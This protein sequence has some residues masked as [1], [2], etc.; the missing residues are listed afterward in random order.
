RQQHTQRLYLGHD[1][2]ILSL[3]IHPVKDYVATGQVGRDAAIHV[4]DTQTLKCLSLLKG[5]H[6]RGVCAL[7]FSADGKCLASVGLDDNHAIVFWD[8]KKGEKLAT[9][10]GHK[11]KIFVV[12]CNPHHVDKLVTVG[13]KHIKFWQ[14]TG[15]GFTSKRGTFGTTGKLETMMSVSYGRIEDIVFS[16]AATGDIYIWKDTLLLKTVKAHDGPVFAMHALDKSLF[17]FAIIL[18]LIFLYSS[19]LLLEDNPS[20]RAISLGH[21]H[22]LVGT[23]NGEILEIDKSGPMTLLVQ[24]HME[25]EVWGLA[26]HPLLP[27]CA[28]VSDDKTLRIWELSSQHR[29]LAVRKLKKGGRCCAFSPDGKALAVGLNDGSFLVV[30]ADTVEDMVSFHHRKE[31]ISDIKFSRESGKYLAVASHDNFVDIYNV[32]TSKRVGICKGASSYITHIDWDSRGKLLQV[33]SG[34]KEQLFFEAPRGKRHVIRIAEIEKIEWDTWTCVLGPTCEGIWPM[35]SDVTIVNA[36]SLTK[37]GTLLATGDDF[38]FVKLFSYPVKGQH[39]KFKKYVGHSAQVTNVRWLHNDSVLLT[40]GGAD[41]ALMIW[42]REFLGIQESKL[43]D[44]EESDTDAEE[45]GGYDSDVAREKAIDYTTKIYAVS[46]RE[47]EGTKPHQQ[48]KE[49]SVEER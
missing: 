36:A 19:G 49:V 48:L 30:N 37:D 45:D 11:D 27:V 31:M 23:K 4:W 18:K 32:L 9:T 25:G 20:I 47:M 46:I 7:D 21:G 17:D 22:I 29:M 38:G 34:A 5:Q 3:S 2:D 8:W 1:D 41:T 40:V 26:A 33:N 12:K 39:A 14:Q 16:G 44:S 15:G 10:R 35:H 13:M 24:G 28:T 42:T 6:Q 43:V